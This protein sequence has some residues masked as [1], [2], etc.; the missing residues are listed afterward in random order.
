MLHNDIL[1]LEQRL[2]TPEAKAS[3]AILDDLI[4]EEFREFGASGRVYDKARIVA[5]LVADPTLSTGPSIV[6]FRIA[7]LAP[8]VVLATYRLGKALRS[9]V[10]RRERGTWRI[11]FHQATPSPPHDL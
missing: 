5:L 10:W 3:A 6:D 2:L 4:S 1:A 8:D 9:S 7:E 11:F